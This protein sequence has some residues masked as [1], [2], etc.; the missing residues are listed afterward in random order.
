MLRKRILILLSGCVL[1]ASA[2]KADD[3]GYIDCRNHPDETQVFAK[4]RQTHETVGSLPCG[5]RFTILLYG[6]IFSRIQTR[7]GK[8]GYV[9]SSVISADR[10]SGT[11]APSVAKAPAANPQPAAA[12]APVAQPKPAATEPPASA[13]AQVTAVPAPTPA[14]A[15][16]SATVASQPTATQAA[17]TSVAAAAVAPAAAADTSVTPAASDAGASAQPSAAPAPTAAPEA[18][19]PPANVPVTP[20]TD[21]AP[22]AQPEAS[23]AEA[24]P[25]AAP[26]VKAANARESW[27][28]PNAGMR[29]VGLRRLPLIEL[30]GG[31]AFTRFDSG[32]AGYTSY[33]NFN[34]VLGSFGWNVRP[35]LQIVADSS[36]SVVTVSG[37][38]NVLYGNH[39]G[40]RI[41]RRVRNRWGITPFVEGLVGGSRAD[42]TV[43]GA[44]GYTTSSNCISY[45]A[46]GGVD[47]HPSK[48]IEIRLFDV[49]YYRT[50]FGTNLHQNNYWASTGI[51]IRLFG[52]SE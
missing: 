15:Q 16:P 14:P 2:A 3:L 38:K 40:P 41:F 27:E 4:A 30:F 33:T 18:T 52:G 6:F 29:T 39:Y 12:T 36:Y 13:P 44:G 20:Q 43:S 35:W 37:V 21:A 19:L 48:H 42:A 9:Y 22:A 45:K 17:P 51:V 28:K 24:A 7:D 47:V 46:G 10:S 34:G 5:E 32:T 50:A 8:V 49:D 23:A 26:V 11:L 31:Y 25:P 1:A